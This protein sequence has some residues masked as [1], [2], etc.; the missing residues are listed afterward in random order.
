M[1][2][3]LLIASHHLVTVTVTTANTEVSWSTPPDTYAL[4]SA[5]S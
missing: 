4:L 3:F 1:I 5:M 2:F